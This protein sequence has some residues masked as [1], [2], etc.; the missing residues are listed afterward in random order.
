MVVDGVLIAGQRV[1]DQYGVGAIGIELTLGLVG[2][3][4]RRKVDAA[5]ELQRLIGAEF[6]HQ[7]TRMICLVRAL[8]NMDRRTRYRTHLYHLDIDLL[9]EFHSHPEIQ[10]I[11]NPA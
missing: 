2:D 10:A 6:G 8:L 11:K 3:L 5:I 4:E 9:R 7:R 1:A